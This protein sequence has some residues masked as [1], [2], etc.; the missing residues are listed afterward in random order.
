M[1]LHIFNPEHDMALAANFRNFTASRAGL[2]LRAALDFLP[3]LWADNGDMTLVEDV[4]AAR[5]AYC[6]LTGANCD[7][8]FVNFHQL[9][10]CD[11]SAEED[12]SIHPWGWDLPI[13]KQLVNANG[14]LSAHVPTDENL[15]EIRR[16]SSRQFTAEHLLPRLVKE[17]RSLVGE[18]W[19][20]KDAETVMHLVA[21]HGRVVVKSPWSSSGRG[22]RLV[23]SSNVTDSQSG[24]INNVVAAQG[25]VTVEPF[26]KKVCDLGVEFTAYPNGDVAYSGLSLFHTLNG[27]YEGNI[28][29]NEKYK[30]DI[31]SKYIP[32]E[33][34]ESV[35]GNISKIMQPL[36]NG[37]YTGPFGVDMMIVKEDF[38]GKFLLHPCV[39]LNLRCTMGH[40]A[41]SHRLVEQFAPGIMK[42]TYNGNYELMLQHLPRV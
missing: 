3:A 2:R 16:L 7:A 8:R 35:I 12:F 20:C 38:T 13:V 31:I 14:Q 33:L 40:V 29:A 27:A 1:K 32:T 10:L 34:F 30:R 24:W 15:A 26:Y 11:F 9:S 28:I 22:V 6:R 17:S 19:Y 41:L 4:A 21:E 18:S 39:E 25:G 36:V 23:E 5:T 42:I 37:H